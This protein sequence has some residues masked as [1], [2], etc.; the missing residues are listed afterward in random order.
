MD[1]LSAS[2]F[3]AT[4][5]KGLVIFG[6]SHVLDSRP[7][8]QPGTTFASTSCCI[9]LQCDSVPQSFLTFYIPSRRSLPIV[10]GLSVDLIRT[11]KFCLSF[12]V[13]LSCLRV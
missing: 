9:L 5:V 1:A 2:V 3:K 4:G 10:F 12:R 7:V 6:S 11:A 13:S 8:A